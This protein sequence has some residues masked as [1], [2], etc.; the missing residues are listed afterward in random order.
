MTFFFF[1]FQTESLSKILNVFCLDS[2]RLEPKQKTI[3]PHSGKSVPGI[4]NISSVEIEAHLHPPCTVMRQSA[5]AL[6]SSVNRGYQG[7][8]PKVMPAETV[9]AYGWGQVIPNM[10]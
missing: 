10:V 5:G 6:V 3:R 9:P 2:V 8:K 7:K 4:I 1:F